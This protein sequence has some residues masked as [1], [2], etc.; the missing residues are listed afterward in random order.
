MSIRLFSIAERI[1]WTRLCES[2]KKLYAEEKEA[3]DGSEIQ[4]DS[5]L[6]LDEITLDEAGLLHAGADRVLFLLNSAYAEAPK[7]KSNRS[8]KSKP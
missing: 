8:V 2:I 1:A 6:S 5:Q 7:V 4:R 3:I